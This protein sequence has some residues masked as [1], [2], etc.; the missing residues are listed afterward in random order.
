MSIEI[1]D[2]DN[3]DYDFWNGLRGCHVHQKIWKP[4]IGQVITFAREEKILM[5][6]LLFLVQ[7]R[8][9]EK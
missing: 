4:F 2:I 6:D 9:L 7:P 3:I 5:I 8:C 1:V